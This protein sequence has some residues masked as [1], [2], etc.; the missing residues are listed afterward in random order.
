MWAQ[1]LQ[2]SGVVVHAMHPGWAD[3]P[4]VESS[5]PRFYTLT[6]V[7]LRTPQE[8]ADT[9]VWLGAAPQGA[10]SSGGF[11]H[12]R[13]QRPTHLLPWT[14]QT[15]RP[16]ATVGRMRAPQRLADPPDPAEM[17]SR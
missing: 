11:W 7:L 10:N 2:G 4:G 17:N 8:G 15:R 12:D 1:R 13:R 5:L 3:T 6:K 16:H 14:K 9:I